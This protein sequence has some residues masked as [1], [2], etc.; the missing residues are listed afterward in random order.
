MVHRG[1]KDGGTT[2]VAKIYAL[3]CRPILVGVHSKVNFI[4]KKTTWVQFYQHSTGSIFYCSFCSFKQN[5]NSV[6]AHQ[7]MLQG[8]PEY[9]E[10]KLLVDLNILYILAYKSK[11]FI[12]NLTNILTIWLIR[13]S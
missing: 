12:Q 9:M 6:A 8:P 1:I 7:E 10:Q 13:R 3:I 5:E 2:D 4:G 11:Y